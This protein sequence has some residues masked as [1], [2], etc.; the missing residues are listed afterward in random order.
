M[1]LTS[2][3]SPVRCL[4]VILL[5]HLDVRGKDGRMG[6]CPRT[7][8]FPLLW[9]G[10]SVLLNGV[11]RGR[12]ELIGCRAQVPNR[13][14]AGIQDRRGRSE[15][16]TGR[17]TSS[18]NPSEWISL[19][20]HSALLFHRCLAMRSFPQPAFLTAL[21]SYLALLAAGH[22]KAIPRI[23]ASWAGEKRFEF[24]QTEPHLVLFHEPGS[25]SVYV[26]GRGKLYYFDFNHQE[27]NFKEDINSTKGDCPKDQ[28]CDNYLTLLEKQDDGLLICGTRARHPSCWLRTNGTTKFQGEKRG[29]APFSPNENSLVL[30]DG[31]HVYSTI[32]KQEHNGKIPRFRRIKGDPELYTSDTVMQNPQFIKATIIHQN[33]SYNDKIYYFFREDNPDKNPEAPLNVSRVAQLCKGD[34]GGESSLSASKWNTFLKAMLVCSDPATNKN[35]NWLQD[36]FI[37]PGNKDWKETRVYGIFSNPWNYSAVCVYSIGDIDHIFRTSPLKGFSDSLPSPRPGQ[38]LPNQ[39]LTPTVTFK[40]ADSH[41]EVTQRVE[42]MG[43]TKTPLFHSKY[44]YQKI[45]VHQMQDKD[46][47]TFNVL[48]IATDKGTIHKVVES[49]QGI[50]NIMEIKPFHKPA[51]IQ[52][53]ILDSST[54]KLYVSSDREVTQVPLDMCASYVGGCQACLLARDPYCGWTGSKCNSIYQHPGPML[55]AVVHEDPHL[56][57]PTTFSG[58]AKPFISKVTVPPNSRYY[59]NCSV[60]SHHATYSWHHKDQEVQQCEPGHQHAACIHFITILTPEKANPQGQWNTLKGRKPW[61]RMSHCSSA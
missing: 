32:K 4:S 52:S 42:P 12:M 49:E 46:N 9:R 60:E 41:P 3:R 55:Q 17:T 11:S 10:L 20:S 7:S 25:H 39:Q 43:L 54:R 59:L 15:P 50:F 23:T 24:N 53:L 5:E 22:Q 31:D 56:L 51:A 36:V 16:G 8:F 13:D 61:R 29:Y 14:G 26:G 1:P 48:F 21:L 44:H 58:D 19:S 40:V 47:G 33:Q 28:D 2:N 34:Q 35:F 57:C 18:S 45:V 6:S 37:V 38:C 27:N 30:I